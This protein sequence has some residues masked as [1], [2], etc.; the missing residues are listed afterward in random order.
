M[1]LKVW[2]SK[3]CINCGK[4]HPKWQMHTIKAKVANAIIGYICKSC[5]NKLEEL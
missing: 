3:R 5:F 4:Y 2:A 1:E